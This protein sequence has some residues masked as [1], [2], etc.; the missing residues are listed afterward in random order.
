MGCDAWCDD[1]KYPDAC[2]KNCRAEVARY[3]AET[4]IRPKILSAE[5]L[6]EQARKDAQSTGSVC[7]VELCVEVHAAF[8]GDLRFRETCFEALVSGDKAKGGTVLVSELV[9]MASERITVTV[10]KVHSCL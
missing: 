2:F 10:E 4:G 3:E 8:M 5:E 7:R 1:A 9:D 6:Q